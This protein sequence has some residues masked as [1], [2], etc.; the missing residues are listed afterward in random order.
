MDERR[1]VMGVRGIRRSALPVVVC[2]MVATGVSCLKLPEQETR[3]TQ[4][5]KMSV[6]LPPRPNLKVQPLPDRHP[7]GVFTVEGFLRKAKEIYAAAP[8]KRGASVRGY[9]QEVVRCPEGSELCPTVPHLVLVDN[10]ASARARLTVVSDPPEAVLDGF[11][12]H[13][14]QT[15]QGEV[16]LWSPDGRLVDLRGLLVI[17]P[18][19]LEQ[20]ESLPIRKGA[21]ATR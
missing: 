18:R 5:K 10:L 21:P 15:L 12:R 17:K 7:D 14:E 9:V 8:E 13:S 11:P 16:A 1:C 20:A 6:T 2:A 3:K 19:P 4:A